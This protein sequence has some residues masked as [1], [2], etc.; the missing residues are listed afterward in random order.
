MRR[1]TAV[2]LVVSGIA[3]SAAGSG[4]S[5]LPTRTITV[6]GTVVA[7]AASSDNNGEE[8]HAAYV[9][10]DH[11]CDTLLVWELAARRVQTLS[12]RR[13]D[14]SLYA[15][16]LAWLEGATWASFRRTADG[17]RQYTV[18]HAADGAD[19]RAQYAKARRVAHESVSHGTSPTLVMGGEGFVLGRRAYSQDGSR[20]QAIPSFEQTPR[21]FSAAAFEAAALSPD[22][23][24]GMYWLV[25]SPDQPA[26]HATAV[27]PP[28]SVTAV[29][30]EPPWDSIVMQGNRLTLTSVRV[31]GSGPHTRTAQ[32]EL[33]TA[34]SYG[35]DRCSSDRAAP[36]NFGSQ[37]KTV[38]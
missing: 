11:G 3:C 23:L 1:I 12:R 33:P 20:L 15:P 27:Y 22:G 29:R 36:R 13:C 7:L 19:R 16:S 31:T 32:L 37:T 18:W 10:R 9:V 8:P 25:G 6:P 2:L 28:T 5:A 24:L 35:D 14:S 26:P 4:S 17:S 30:T 34:S 21:R 38:A